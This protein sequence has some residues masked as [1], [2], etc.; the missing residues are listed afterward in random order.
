MEHTSSYSLDYSISLLSCLDLSGSLF[1][2]EYNKQSKGIK[3]DSIQLKNDLDVLENDYRT[4][5]E[6]VLRD[7]AE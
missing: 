5:V 1:F 4:A 7:E 2:R 3:Y 6:K